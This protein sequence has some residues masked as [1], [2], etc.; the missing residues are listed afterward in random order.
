MK[1]WMITYYHLLSPAI[2]ITILIIRN[3]QQS[4]TILSPHFFMGEEADG[5]GIPLTG[6]VIMRS[7]YQDEEGQN[8]SDTQPSGACTPT[9]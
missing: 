2:S 9:Q 3:H 4:L 5:G 7:V 8:T 1:P 6:D